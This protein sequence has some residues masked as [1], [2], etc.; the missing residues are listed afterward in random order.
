MIRNEIKLLKTIIDNSYSPYSNL[1]VAAILKTKSGKLYPG[2]NVEN[3]GIIS[4]CAEK[5]AFVNAISNGEKDFEYIIIAARKKDKKQL[6]PIVP[7]GS[8]RQFISEFVSDD[9]K[10]YAVEE[11]YIKEYKI[12]DLLPFTFKL[13]KK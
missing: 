5:S 1:K 9:F 2:V 10:I 4:V 13:D 11:E 6:E 7:C 8:C 12:K 3:A